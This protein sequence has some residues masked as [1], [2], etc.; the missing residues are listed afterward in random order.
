MVFTRINNALLVAHTN[1]LR[2]QPGILDTSIVEN[3]GLRP[4]G[5]KEAPRYEFL[6]TL[7]FSD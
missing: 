7:V 3:C 6:E 2:E 1:S 5:V 4:A